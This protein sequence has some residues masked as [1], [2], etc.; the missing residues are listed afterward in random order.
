[1]PY[2]PCKNIWKAYFATTVKPFWQHVF[3]ISMWFPKMLWCPS[4][5]FIKEKKKKTV[6][7]KKGFWCCSYWRTKGICQY[8]SRS[9]Y[10]NIIHT[11]TVISSVHCVNSVRV[12]SF[13]GPCFPA[14]RFNTSSITLNTDTFHGLVKIDE[15]LSPKPQTKN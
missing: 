12:W 11:Q 13:S 7:N 14:F 5:S 15:R 3:K 6:D 4:L 1:M 2:N 8:K 10:S 9:S